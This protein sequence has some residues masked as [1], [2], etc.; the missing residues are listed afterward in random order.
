MARRTRAL[1]VLAALFA[2]ALAVWAPAAMAHHNDDHGK[3]GGTGSDQA[4]TEDNDDDG[5]P[6][7]P[8]PEGDSDNKHPSG[9]DKHEEAGGSGN[10][11][12]TTSDPDDDGRGPDRSNGGVDQPGGTGGDDQL[13]QD[14]NNGCGND[15]DFEDDNEGLCQGPVKRQNDRSDEVGSEVIELCPDGSAMPASGNIEEC[16]ELEDD[17]IEDEVEGEVIVDHPCPDNPIMDVLFPERCDEGSDD[18]VAG[19]VEENPSA[20][21]DEGVEEE[22]NSVLGIRVTA[23]PEVA[24]APAIAAAAVG[25][26]PEAEGAVLPFTGTSDLVAF[27]LVALMLIGSGTLALRGRRVNA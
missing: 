16:D 4:V 24:S 12:K 22:E 23:A 3:G 13:D 6:N 19:G 10:Q 21:V 1:T 17:V 25:A 20:P 7:A 18:D 11:G 15:D 27:A 8:D 9:K 5:Q 14:G 26:A 2:L